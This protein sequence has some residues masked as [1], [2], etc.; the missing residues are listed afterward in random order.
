M[1]LLHPTP[2]PCVHLDL[3]QQVTPRTDGCEECLAIGD[4]WVHLRLCMICGHVGC[5]DFSKNK[6]A[7]K[8]FHSTRHAIIKSLEP[9]EDWMWCFV[10]M[11]EVQSEDGSRS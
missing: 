9:G 8:H 2:G 10:D 1:R 5:C 7:T 11:M 6:H 3:I 4:T